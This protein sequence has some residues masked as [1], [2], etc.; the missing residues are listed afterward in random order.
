M[1]VP[2]FSVC[3]HHMG[4]A[5]LLLRQNI[6]MYKVLQVPHMTIAGQ[7]TAFHL[8]ASGAESCA[9]AIHQGS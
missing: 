7:R 6:K 2:E 9:F 3:K 5:V 1:K 8:L 4:L